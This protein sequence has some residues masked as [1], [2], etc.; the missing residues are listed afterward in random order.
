[1]SAKASGRVWDLELPH[2]K[3]LV[4]LALADHADHEGGGIY[5]SLALIEW[6][7]G[8]SVRQIQRVIAL[9]VDD[10]ILELVAPYTDHRP[11]VYRLNLS[12]GKVKPPFVSPRMREQGRQNVA[13]SASKSP[14]EGRQNVTPRVDISTQEGGHFEGVRVDIAMSTEP[15]M[16]R[17]DPPTPTQRDPL[18]AGGGDGGFYTELRRRKIG[19][20]KAREIAALGGDCTRILAA[21]DR[22]LNTR[23]LGG[24][25]NDILD[26]VIDAPPATAPPALPPPV[27]SARLS[28]D[29]MRTLNAQYGPFKQKERSNGA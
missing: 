22:Q 29:E 19:P 1:M 8:Y 23:P 10:G 14:R 7:T 16:N 5:P 15:T 27:P 18:P 12:A 3:R 25:I 28:P 24:I 13:P 6:K 4:L 9:L 20:T 11:N 21:I 2:N 17:H 26:G